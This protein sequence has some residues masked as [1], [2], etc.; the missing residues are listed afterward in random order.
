MQ[1]NIIKSNKIKVAVIPVGTG[2]DWVKTYNIP[3]NLE[4]AVALIK[5]EFTVLQDIGKIKVLSNDRISFFNNAAG[6]GFDAYVVH[7]IS[8]F[9]KLGSMTYLVSALTSFFSYKKSEMIINTGTK[10]I[11]SKIFM[12]TI[13]LCKYSG[14]GM[15]LTDYKNHKSGYF[16]LT[17]IKNITLKK[18]IFNIK[19]LF[20][21]KII[22]L[23]E[24]DALHSKSLKI[25]IPENHLPYIQADGELLGSGNCEINIIEKA[26]QF[27]VPNVKI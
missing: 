19:K 8:T 12:I 6:L 17:L 14:G 3:N 26:I 20:N 24:V 16:D 18:V 5:N 1:Q 11:K 9:K 21:G 27:V 2:N 25:T 22:H 7:K 4:K 10:N 23:K 15:Q 13:G